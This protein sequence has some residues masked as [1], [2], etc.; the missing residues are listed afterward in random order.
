ML[1]AQH[2]DIYARNAA[3]SGDDP[4]MTGSIFLKPTATPGN[5]TLP[6]GRLRSAAAE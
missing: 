1:R 4:W 3:R 2:N 5:N 6:P